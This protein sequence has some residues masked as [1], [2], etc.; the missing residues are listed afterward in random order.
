MMGLVSV[1]TFDD[2]NRPFRVNNSP[3]GYFIVRRRAARSKSENGP[4][5]GEPSTGDVLLV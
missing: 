4:L 2:S 3:I 1:L 5:W